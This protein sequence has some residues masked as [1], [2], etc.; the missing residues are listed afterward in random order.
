MLSV[1]AS[2]M[3]V[4]MNASA[5]GRERR[6]A[7]VLSLTTDP[8]EEV[9]CF[10]IPQTLATTGTYAYKED[11]PT[12]VKNVNRAQARAHHPVVGRPELMYDTLKLAADTGLTMIVYT[13]EPGSSSAD[14]LTLLAS[15][16]ATP[17][18]TDLTPAT[19]RP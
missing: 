18:Q 12:L 16:A 19:E 17:E 9:R 8:P 3:Q 13:A 11:P 14:A 7:R 15:W 5:A 2:V 6:R 1:R 4:A 10:R